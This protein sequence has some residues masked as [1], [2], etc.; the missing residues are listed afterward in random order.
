MVTP[1]KTWK[2]HKIS[3]IIR[4]RDEEAYIRD[5]LRILSVQTVE[6]SELVI[7]DN[8]SCQEKFQQMRVLLVEAKKKLFK[9]E[10]SIKLIPLAKL[11]FSHPYATNLGVSYSENEIVCITNGHALPVSETWIEDGLVHFRD[12]MVAGVGGYFHPF[13]DASTWEKLRSL[14]WVTHKEATSAKKNDLYFSTINCLLK[15]SFWKEYPFDENL[16]QTMPESRRYGGEDYDWGLEMVARGYKI[17]IEPNFNVFHSHGESFLT[18]LSKYV[19]YQRI[20]ARMRRFARPRKSF[21]RVSNLEN[22]DNVYQL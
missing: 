4:T 10:I 7:V 6:P 18:F 11:D 5:L 3:V 16:C 20:K 22:N 12:P 8:F 2:H 15:K 1:T 14:M 17:V 13:S 19:A 21:A 9:N